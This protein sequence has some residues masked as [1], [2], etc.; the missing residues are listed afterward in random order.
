MLLLPTHISHHVTFLKWNNVWQQETKSDA[1]EDFRTAF[2]LCSI[3]KVRSCTVNQFHATPHPTPSS[4]RQFDK[5]VRNSPKCKSYSFQWRHWEVQPLLN[6]R[7]ASYHLGFFLFLIRNL[8]NPW[9]VEFM[10]K[11]EGGIS[12]VPYLVP[13]K[14]K[15]P[16]SL[17][18]FMPQ[19]T[20]TWHI[21][22]PNAQKIISQVSGCSKKNK[23]DF[24]IAWFTGWQGQ[25]CI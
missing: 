19:N 4:K 18:H 10:K 3:S 15:I 11:E 13:R 6:N 24:A 9:S 8:Y 5:M 12:A 21:L 16:T 2:N 1:D 7:T 20:S 22:L 14:P 25:C 23:R 17:P